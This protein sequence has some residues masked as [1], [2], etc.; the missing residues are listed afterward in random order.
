MNEV[1]INILE[2]TSLQ[3]FRDTPFRGGGTCVTLQFGGVENVRALNRTV[4][5]G[6]VFADRT[7]YGCFVVVPF[8]AVESLLGSVFVEGGL[9]V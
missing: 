8:G 2:S 6:E 3:A 7:T 4:E 1:Q 9:R 5:T